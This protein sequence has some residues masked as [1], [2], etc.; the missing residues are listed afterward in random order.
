MALQ[1]RGEGRLQGGDGK[2]SRQEVGRLIYDMAVETTSFPDEDSITRA[3]LRAAAAELRFVEGFLRSVRKSAQ[4]SC[5]EPAD[6]DL[7]HFA[8]KLAGKV[9]NVAGEIE[10]ELS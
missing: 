3:E 8:G 9:G 10:G 1:Q 6:D 4:D 7:A 5:L 2:L